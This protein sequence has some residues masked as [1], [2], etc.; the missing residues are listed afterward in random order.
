[1]LENM[2]G[3]NSIVEIIN[4]KTSNKE[5]EI[6]EE[7][8][9]QKK[10]K[11]EEAQRKAKEAAETIT[12]KAELQAKSEMSRYE[13]SAKLKSKYKMLES[14]EQLIVDVL[15]AATQRLDNTVGK[16]EYKKILTKLA[17]EGG[18]ALHGDTLEL[19]LPKSHA[20]H[21]DVAEIEKSIQK[22]TGTKTKITISKETLRAKGGVIV[23]TPD[24]KKSVENTFEARL[25]RLEDK[26]REV[27]AGVLFEDENKK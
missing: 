22:E 7:A 26:V 25:E 12:K 16:A 24:S 4:T 8:E 20:T 15:E 5:K 6:L 10:L 2:S 9:Q 3:I 1:M 18:I 17:I 11:L 14:K 27:I 13:A 21:I 19:V 23:R